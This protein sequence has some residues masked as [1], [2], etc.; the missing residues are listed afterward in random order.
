M[1]VLKIAG[2]QAIPGLEFQVSLWN[3]FVSR[4]KLLRCGQ[5]VLTRK[6]QLRSSPGVRIVSQNSFQLK[7][8]GLDGNKE[9]PKVPIIC[10]LVLKDYFLVRGCLP[11]M[12]SWPGRGLGCALGTQTRLAF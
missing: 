11:V 3:P 1:V 2:E 8:W 6:S 7:H 12:Q 4:G 10:D 9:K 5:L